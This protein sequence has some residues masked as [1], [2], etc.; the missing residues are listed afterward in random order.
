AD[1]YQRLCE[2]W[3][4]LM[5]PPGQRLLPG[6]PLTHNYHGIFGAGHFAC[7][8]FQF[9]YYVA[10]ANKRVNKSLFS[11]YL[12][13]DFQSKVPIIFES[14]L[15]QQP[16]EPKIDRLRQELF[17]SRLNGLHRYVSRIPFG[18]N[19]EWNGRV[20]CSKTCQ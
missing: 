8:H 3:T 12:F 16:K 10:F 11:S 7:E 4:I 13:R 5:N 1:V 17:C 14:L 2:S 9:L 6:A 15:D 19:Q 20:D 18:Q